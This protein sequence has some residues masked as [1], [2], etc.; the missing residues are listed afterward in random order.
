MKNEKPDLQNQIGCITGFFQLFDS[1]RFF[2]GQ[3]TSSHSQH[4]L[5]S[6]ILQHPSFSV[7][8]F[9]SYLDRIS[10]STTVNFVIFS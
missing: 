5:T 6:G 4:R 10:T 2:T 1:H 7:I 9:G 8:P 3:H